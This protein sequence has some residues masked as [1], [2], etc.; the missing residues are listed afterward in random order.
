LPAAA[1]GEGGFAS[2][3]TCVATDGD[4][5][6]W[7]ATGNT[8]APRVLRTT[9]RGATWTAAPAPVVGGEAAGLASVAVIGHGRLVA[10][11]GPIGAPDLRADAVAVSHD[12][13]AT[14]TA[15]GRLP[16]AGAAYGAA[17]VPGTDAVVAVGPGGVALSRDGGATW[18]ALST[19]THWGLA[20]AGRTGW[21]VGPDGRITRIGF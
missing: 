16:F 18:S 6:A 17:V 20:M 8:A 4:R 11:G 9:D 12:G 7:V 14:W 1:P 3:G 13:G 2:S 19:E 10:V 15:G 5:T 21:L